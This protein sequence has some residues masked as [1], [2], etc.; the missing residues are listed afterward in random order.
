[1]TGIGKYV[2]S[3]YQKSTAILSKEKNVLRIYD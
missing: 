1:M 3:I 2:F